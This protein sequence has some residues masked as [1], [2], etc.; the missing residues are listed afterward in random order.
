MSTSSADDR[1]RELH[2]RLVTWWFGSTADGTELRG[3]WDDA[4]RRFDARLRE[5]L[6]CHPGDDERLLETAP[7][8]LVTCFE[9]SLDDHDHILANFPHSLPEG[10]HEWL[11]D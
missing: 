8:L 1:I 5:F 11:G 6:D 3:I 2:E 9:R 10:W 7:D 4:F